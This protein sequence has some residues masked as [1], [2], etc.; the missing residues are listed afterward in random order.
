MNIAVKQPQPIRNNAMDNFFYNWCFDRAIEKGASQED[1]KYYAVIGVQKFKRRD[2]SGKPV[3][4]AEE[5]AR[6]AKKMTGAK[7]KKALKTKQNR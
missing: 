2:F 7:A 6:Q 4:L 1:A 5:M 3:D